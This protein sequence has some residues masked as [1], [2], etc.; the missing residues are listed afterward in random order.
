MTLELLGLSIHD[1]DVA[2][3]DFGLAIIG[4]YL[5]WRL[6]TR[7]ARTPLERTGIALMLGL[8]SA[9]FWGGIF[10]GFFPGGTATAAGSIAWMP[11]G[12]SIVVV[13]AALLALA[14]SSLTPRLP[15]RA[16]RSLVALYAAGFAGV[17]LAVDASFATIVR[18]YAPALALALVGSVRQAIGARGEAG[19]SLLACGFALSVLAAAAQQSQLGIHAVYFDHNAVYHLVQGI[20]LV[21]LY[22]GFGREPATAG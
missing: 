10:H 13:A 15:R 17:V 6:R 4:A 19:W 5:A 3:T 20:A 16:R 21:V 7:E 8:A 2:L 12:L 18:F 22:L 1:P 11:V 9:A 14:L